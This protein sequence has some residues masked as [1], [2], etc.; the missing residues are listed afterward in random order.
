MFSK[1]LSHALCALIG[2][3]VG[4]VS[5]MAIT[6]YMVPDCGYIIRNAIEEDWSKEDILTAVDESIERWSK[7]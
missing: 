6:A 1:I 5:I 4:G 2:A 3:A 7:F